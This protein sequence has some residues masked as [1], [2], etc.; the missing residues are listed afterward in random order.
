[1]SG[2]ASQ[3]EKKDLNL[4]SFPFVFHTFPLAVAPFRRK[5]STR[6]SINGRL[7]EKHGAETLWA[8]NRT[9]MDKYTMSARRDGAVWAL[10]FQREINSPESKTTD[11]SFRHFVILRWEKSKHYKDCTENC[12]KID[13]TSRYLSS[14]SIE[15]RHLTEQ[16]CFPKT[17]SHAEM[18]LARSVQWMRL[19][20]AGNNSGQHYTKCYEL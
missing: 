18:F 15:M 6:W 11:G 3:V 20:W 12:C 13:Y 2:E 1:M 7:G 17:I 19:R 14:K 4:I 10:F 9:N 8:I 5:G 16:K